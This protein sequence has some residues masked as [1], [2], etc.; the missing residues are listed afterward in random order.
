MIWTNIPLT[1]VQPCTDYEN[2]V[3]ILNL[4]SARLIR[5]QP[6][7]WVSSCPQKESRG[8]HTRCSLPATGQ[9]PATCVTEAIF[10]LRKLLA[11]VH[12]EFYNNK[13]AMALTALLWKNAPFHRSPKAQHAFEQLKLA[14]CL[15]GL[16]QEQW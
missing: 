7:S 11:E 9:P 3:S 4:R 1:S 8:I 14:S 12:F 10:K 6:N 2:M 15:G 13:K 5:P 16:I